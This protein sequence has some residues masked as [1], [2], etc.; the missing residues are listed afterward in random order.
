MSAFQ[1]KIAL[2]LSALQLLML[3]VGTLMYLEPKLFFL[4]IFY[5]GTFLIIKILIAFNMYVYIFY[6]R[7]MVD[8]TAL[9]EFL[10]LYN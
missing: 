9:T 10:L 7:I 6:R 2:L 1:A 3:F 8:V 4:I 5:S